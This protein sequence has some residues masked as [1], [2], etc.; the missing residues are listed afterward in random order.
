M[1][2]LYSGL[3]SS[4]DGSGSGSG[5]WISMKL[6]PNP[7]NDQSKSSFS[8]TKTSTNSDGTEKSTSK[9]FNPISNSVSQSP[10]MSISGDGE[11]A[12]PDKIQSL[13][14]RIAALKNKIAAKVKSAP[15]ISTHSVPPRQLVVPNVQAVKKKSESPK[16]VGVATNT[17]KKI[18]V[19]LTRDT[20]MFPTYADQYD[21]RQPNDYSDYCERRL[22]KKKKERA[23]RDL[24]RQLQ[25]LDEER[26]RHK[27]E[28]E[29]SGYARLNADVDIARSGGRGRGR[30][31][32]IP[33]WMTTTSLF[34]YQ[35][36]L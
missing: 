15:I 17:K 13:E 34:Y 4:T 30:S 2:D 25:K 19:N 36:R 9:T 1:S 8:S 24:E 29:R 6:R 5:S 10:L 18:Q 32:T 16:E 26:R 7:K 12:N 14:Q 22:A 11:V 3:P 28:E 27:E 31:Q 21:P 35:L 23:K 20:D 33:A